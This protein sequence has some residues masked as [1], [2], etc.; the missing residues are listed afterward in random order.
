[1]GQQRPPWPMR[2]DASAAQYWLRQKEGEGTLWRGLDP[3]DRL[4]STEANELNSPR[5]KIG[6]K[7]TP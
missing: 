6:E 1:M 5:G 3:P 7:N 4:L 2:P